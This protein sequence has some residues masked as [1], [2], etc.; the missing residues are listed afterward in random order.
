MSR[1]TLAYATLLLAAFLVGRWSTTTAPVRW[2]T[3]TLQPVAAGFVDFTGEEEPDPE[4]RSAGGPE[5]RRV[6]P[7]DEYS[8]TP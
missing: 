2:V 8:L 1:R 7:D 3:H 5:G 4:A 6:R